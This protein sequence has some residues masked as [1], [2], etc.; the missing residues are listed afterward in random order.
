MWW[1]LLQADSFGRATMWNRDGQMEKQMVTVN[2]KYNSDLHWEAEI[3]AVRA[4]V[5]STHREES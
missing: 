2:Q 4:L 1:L 5:L 3:G